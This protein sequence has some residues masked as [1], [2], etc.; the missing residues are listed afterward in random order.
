MTEALGLA[1]MAETPVVVNIG[2][3]PGPSTGLATHTAQGELLFAIH[4]S[5][6][7]FPRF[8]LAPGDV[9]ECFY[10]TKTAF[11]L[12]DKYQVPALIL[13]DRYLAESEKDTTPFELARVPIDR[14]KLN[15]NASWDGEYQRYKIT[16]DGVSPR[17]IP[18]TK[19]ATVVSNSNEHKEDGHTTEDPDKVT[20]IFEKRW[21][22]FPS[23]LREVEG[24][25]PAKMFGEDGAE[26]TLVSWGGNKGPILEAIRMLKADG[27]RVN[28]LQVIFLEPFPTKTI[29]DILSKTKRGIIVENN[30]TSQLGTL[31]KLHVGYSFKDAILR[32]DGR[33]F[34]PTLIAQKVKEVLG[35]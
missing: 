27:V 29:M 35:K 12:A 1:A 7:E 26:V 19:G 5:H 17:L 24:L 15:Q 10:L 8:V 3:R 28:Y 6:G 21:R 2:Q 22:K 4:A 16:E 31:F 14:G 11:N 13:T 34:T 32:Y 25:E 18:G 30:F 33:P 23:M 9:D 20:A